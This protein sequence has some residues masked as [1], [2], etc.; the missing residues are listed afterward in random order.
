MATEYACTICGKTEPNQLDLYTRKSKRLKDDDHRREQSTD[1]QREQGHRWG[2]RQGYAVRKV[3]KDITSGFKDVKRSDFDRALRV[4]ADS[5]V[6]ALWAYAIDRFSRKGAEDLSSARPASSSTWTGWTPTSPVTVDGS[7]YI[8]GR[9]KS[10][11]L[12]ARVTLA[13]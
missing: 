5:E 2:H 6:P 11:A 8:P 10:V 1:A 12:T 7:S 3:W 13:P 4:L 9:G